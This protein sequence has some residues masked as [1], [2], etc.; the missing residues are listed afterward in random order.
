MTA[1]AA[2][3]AAA[4]A[5]TIMGRTFPVA[6]QNLANCCCRCQTH[7]NTN[8]IK[9][10]KLILTDLPPRRPST[11]VWSWNSQNSTSPVVKAPCLQAPQTPLPLRTRRTPAASSSST[12]T[13]R[14]PLAGKPF[15]NGW[16]HFLKANVVLFVK[17]THLILSFDIF[18]QLQILSSSI[19][20]GNA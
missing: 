18:Q 5:A 13:P 16:S 11:P 20:L 8:I 9:A 7:N 3:A 2:A 1:A 12:S 4:E 17:S 10:H 15:L 6:S 14:T 19:L